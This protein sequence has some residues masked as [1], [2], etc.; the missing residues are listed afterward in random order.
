MYF[1]YLERCDFGQLQLCYFLYACSEGGGRERHIPPSRF[2]PSRWRDESRVG[3]SFRRLPRYLSGRGGGP[4]VVIICHTAPAS[5]HAPS[6]PFANLP[7]AQANL[8]ASFVSA[9]GGGGHNAGRVKQSDAVA[10]RREAAFYHGCLAP[11]AEPAGLV[12]LALW[13]ASP[14]R[15]SPIARRGLQ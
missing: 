5:V 9:R 3:Q 1:T 15:C 13:P 10:C 6:G 12:R 7:P 11:A 2:V 14:R 8:S 4:P